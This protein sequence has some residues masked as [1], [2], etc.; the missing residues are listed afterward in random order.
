ML[1]AL[2][3][4]LAGNALAMDVDELDEV[5]LDK[6]FEEITFLNLDNERLLLTVK[7]DDYAKTKEFISTAES[8]DFVDYDGFS[9]LELAYDYGRWNIVLLLLDNGANIN[10]KCI[11]NVLSRAAT[12]GNLKHVT[13]FLDQGAQIN[14]TDD[15][16]DTALDHATDH[17]HKKV[18]QLL[19]S[20]GAN[21]YR[22]KQET[23]TPTSLSKAIILKKVDLIPVYIKAILFHCIA[24]LPHKEESYRRLLTHLCCIQ[25]RRDD[26]NCPTLPKELE[27]K[28][29]QSSDEILQDI[30]AG[31]A[32]K[33]NLTI[34]TFLQELIRQS[35]KLIGTNMAITALNRLFHKQ[36]SETC[37]KMIPWNKHPFNREE[38]TPIKAY[39]E[40]DALPECIA[41]SLETHSETL[42]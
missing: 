20:R 39:L 13:F 18:V 6:L 17:G 3:I 15:L 31:I 29:L 11:R 5:E 36:V 24:K 21:I 30:F 35:K 16:G 26:E 8:L 19:I 9:L 33:T 23:L 32:L 12:K 7:Y 38:Y 1:Y 22:N 40:S 41:T 2:I 37:N 34:D 4:G 25:R 14:A 27:E 10:G 28:I 42:N